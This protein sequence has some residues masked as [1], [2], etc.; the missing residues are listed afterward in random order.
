MNRLVMYQKGYIVYVLTTLVWQVLSLTTP[1]GK[2][3]TSVL[4]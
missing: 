2:E 1:F 3:S 4:V